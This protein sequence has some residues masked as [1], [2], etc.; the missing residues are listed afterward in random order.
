MSA[1]PRFPGLK[2]GDGGCLCAS[3]WREALEAGIAAPV[4]H[5]L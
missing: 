5:A 2:P 4:S 3:R 1:V